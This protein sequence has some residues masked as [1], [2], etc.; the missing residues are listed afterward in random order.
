MR[1]YS[2]ILSQITIY[3]VETFDYYFL[4]LQHSLQPRLGLENNEL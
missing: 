3:H 1:F 4:L 2:V